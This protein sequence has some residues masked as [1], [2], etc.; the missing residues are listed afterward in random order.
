MTGNHHILNQPIA[1]K[2]ALEREQKELIAAGGTV[3]GR[4]NDCYVLVHACAPASVAVINIPLKSRR[5]VYKTS[6]IEIIKC[7]SNLVEMLLV[8]M[9]VH[10]C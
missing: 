10:A 4:G 2:K 6:F 1:V 5:N 8:E 3:R 7:V 9:S